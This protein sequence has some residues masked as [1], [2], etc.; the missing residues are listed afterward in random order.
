LSDLLLAKLQNIGLKR[1]DYV[2]LS[3]AH[4]DHLGG[5]FALE[6][7]FE[8]G[9]L[10]TADFEPNGF[11]AEK[12]LSGLSTVPIVLE[13]GDQLTFTDS[14]SAEVL[15]PFTVSSNGD[16]DDSLVLLF[17]IGNTR[18]LFSGDAEAEEESEILSAY[19]EELNCQ[20]LK[21]GHH[22]SSTSTTE[23]FLEAASPMY[24]VIS[25]GKDNSYGLP[26]DLIL[27]RLAEKNIVVYRTDESGDLV[28]QTDGE[29]ILPPS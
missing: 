7:N 22:G 9:Q 21:V 27:E 14:L 10:L 24:A 18:W 23:D 17:R 15:A 1:L 16:N 26:S 19:A 8:I 4:E 5:L 12:W 29:T 6:E 11:L 3:H 25:V 20:V 2:I 13:A 28:F